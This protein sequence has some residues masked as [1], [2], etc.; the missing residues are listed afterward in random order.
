MKTRRRARQ[1]S[2]MTSPVVRFHD[3][4]HSDGSDIE[5]GGVGKVH[6]KVAKGGKGKMTK[7]KKGVTDEGRGEDGKRGA[8][9]MEEDRAGMG[10]GDDGKGGGDGGEI[11]ER[12]V[13]DVERSEDGERGA[14][15]MEEGQAGVGD[16]GDGKGGGDGEEMAPQVDDQEE[17]SEDRDV[18]VGVNDNQTKAGGVEENKDERDSGGMKEEVENS[19][20]TEVRSSPNK[21]P[22]KDLPMPPHQDG[23]EAT[24]YR[25]HI[26]ETT[27]GNTKDHFLSQN[28]NIQHT[29]IKNIAGE[30]VIFVSSQNTAKK[31]RKLTVDCKNKH[32]LE[33][34]KSIADTTKAS[35]TAKEH[36]WTFTTS[37]PANKI[38]GVIKKID[39][40]K[41][42]TQLKVTGILTK[43]KNTSKQTITTQGTEHIT[44]ERRLNYN[45]DKREGLQTDGEQYKQSRA[46]VVSFTNTETLPTAI[47][48]EDTLHYLEGFKFP[49]RSCAKCHSY[50]HGT[51]K[52]TSRFTYCGRCGDTNSGHSFQ[53]CCRPPHC[54]HCKGHHTV[55]D[56]ACPHRQREFLCAEL[57]AGNLRTR[58]SALKEATTLINKGITT[59]KGLLP[60]PTHLP[61]PSPT[62]HFQSPLPIQKPPSSTQHITTAVH[63]PPTLPN[64]PSSTHSSDPVRNLSTSTPQ[65]PTTTP[66]SH[67]PTHS[68][69]TG[70]PTHLPLPTPRIAP[71]NHFNGPLNLTNK[72][73][74]S[75]QPSNHSY[76][77]D[78]PTHLPLPTPQIP[79]REHY[80]G[81]LNPTNKPN[82]SPQPSNQRQNN[83]TTHPKTITPPTTHNNTEN[84]E[85]T[86]LDMD[87][88]YAEALTNTPP[89]TSTGT[90]T[91]KTCKC[92]Q[93]Q[94]AVYKAMD[95]HT[96]QMHAIINDNANT[97][98]DTVAEAEHTHKKEIMDNLAQYRQE[99][100]KL[101]TDIAN[102][103]TEVQHLKNIIEQHLPNKPIFKPQFQHYPSPHPPPHLFHPSRFLNNRQPQTTQSH[104]YAHH[105]N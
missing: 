95:F 4:S 45:A 47:I 100:L 43:D 63:L 10:D 71:R 103:T 23:N 27:H 87:R 50:D 57:R 88:S 24:A 35:K 28:T 13:M 42:I 32:Q 30:G 26:H 91:P 15:Q 2:I 73:I 1:M 105:D 90:C 34:L 82:P 96:S 46:I 58:H 86:S 7:N 40:S 31:S 22:K 104:K 79:P 3:E 48:I 85:T 33:L 66:C 19:Q 77:T 83:N 52:C 38:H 54:L 44:F 65:K 53:N 49:V 37:T 5:T 93:V 92:K 18:R 17:D 9:R 14:V 67:T 102:L 75:P 60:T 99:N 21:K 62:T 56:K 78:P 84:K 51:D 74:N 76:H 41:D 11:D 6:K 81:P 97:L 8:V 39:Q 94:S 98:F 20:W 25:L 12:R 68:F 89:M 59:R 80:N 70:P 61:L 101:K 64:I 29:F 72:D 36:G 16:G 69:H 55:W